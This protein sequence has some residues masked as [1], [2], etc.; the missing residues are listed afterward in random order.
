MSDIQNSKNVVRQYYKAL[1]AAM[2][3]EITRVLLDHTTPGF[4]WRGMHPFN[5]LSGAEEV[6]EHFWKPFRKAIGPI[7]RRPDLFLAG[8]SF[9]GNTKLE[10]V[11][12]MG[13]LMGLF[14]Q[15]WLGIPASGKMVFLRYAEFHRMEKGLIAETVLFCDIL[16]VMLQVG[17]K[18]LPPQTGAFILTPGPRT[19]DGLLYDAQNPV[20]GQITL[21]LI[22]RMLDDLIGA[23]VASPIEDLEK[24]WHPDMLWFG[25]TGIGASYTYERYRR[26]HCAPFEEGLEFIRHNGHE[27]Q[28]GE[29]HYGGFF[30]YPS[31][32]LKCRGGFMGL[33][34]HDKAIE[35]RIVDLYRRD[36]DKLA[37]NWIFIDMLHF[38]NMQGLDVLGRIQKK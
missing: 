33:P 30:G 5:E 23:S 34:A 3:D 24:T 14:D 22:K 7:Q 17:L 10:W 8:H 9:T 15:D 27:C 35:M 11:V 28:I 19:H 4:V 6:A 16:G 38:L 29:G 12:S 26:Q 2:G 25:P 37:E 21:D 36:G 32:T 18:P 1:D 31:L 13:H 20:E